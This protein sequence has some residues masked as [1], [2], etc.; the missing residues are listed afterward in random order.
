VGYEC[1]AAV[2]FARM[3]EVETAKDAGEVIERAREL[4]R[5]FAGRAAEHDREASFPFE[6]F[7][8]L[9]EAGMLSLVVPK[10]H[11]GAGQGLA[12]AARVIEEVA[13]GE[14]STALV[15]AMHYIY[16]GIPALN[17]LWDREFCAHLWRESVDGIALINVMRVEP[18]LGTPSR[19]GLPATTAEPTASGWRISGHKM[20]ATGSPILKYLAVWARTAGDDPKVGWFVVPNGAPGVSTVPTWDHMGMRATG[21]DDLILDGVEIPAN[22]AVD[23]RLPGDWLPPDPVQS[24]WNNVVLAALYNGIAVSARDWLV[25]YLN[26][27][28][29]SNLG[30]S[31]AT[32]PRFQ[33][34]VG[35][36][37][38][39]LFTNQR[40]IHGLAEVA[41]ASGYTQR[42]AGQTSLTKYTA[43]AN[44]IRVVDIA[45][46]LVG[47][48]GLSRHNE[49]ERHHRDVLCSRIHV[50]QDDMVLLGA[51]KAALGVV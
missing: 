39:L 48:P 42:L 40:L 2:Y 16:S 4:A 36:M 34:S 44:A 13:K 29:P 45:L 11:G 18:E 26:E 14:P 15:L 21:S 22:Y 32:L 5:R 37:E 3:G 19:G 50:P 25:G 8:A 33:S 43:N 41:D 10:E 38:A 47:N 24:V 28:K 49:L 27:R 6:N 20:Y 12:V 17:R 23:V 7:N 35:E 1:A 51:G 31:L 9:H 46:S 30:A